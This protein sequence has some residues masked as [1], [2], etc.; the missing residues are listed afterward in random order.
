[1][2]KYC[3][4]VV[5][6]VM[7]A[8]AVFAGDVDQVVPGRYLVTFKAAANLKVVKGHTNVVATLQNQL[9]KNLQA[10]KKSFLGK[11]LNR[12]WICNTVAVSLSAEEAKR[13]KSVAN[14][15]AVEP[16]VVRRWID[17]DIN[18]KTV[19][20]DT[21]KLQWSVEMV[22][23]H[24]VWAKWN[25]DG[26]GVVVGHLDTGIAA[27]HPLLQG[28][29][30][31][32]KDFTTVPQVEAYD[33]QGHGTHTAGSIAADSGVGV[34]PGAKLIVAKVFDRSGSS[35]TEALLGAMQWVMDPDGDPETK[36]GPV[37]VN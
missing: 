21:S 35:S 1:M 22:K 32:F 14:I 29:T 12:L 17:N 18:K 3:L 13:L 4:L 24:E 37:L 20:Y 19:K 36:D 27:Q 25:I 26:T 30:L 7:A 6:F 15:A 10:V 33:D 34:A 23:A 31:A 2:K 5:C 8:G 16:V 9:N 11:A 28:K